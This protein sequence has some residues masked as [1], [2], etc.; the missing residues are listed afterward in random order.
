MDTN[1]EPYI[2]SSIF[3]L[4]ILA[5]IFL[6]AVCAAAEK[7]LMASNKVKSTAHE[8]FEL[9]GAIT[10]FGLSVYAVVL[11][12]LQNN[13]STFLEQSNIPANSFISVIL[14]LFLSTFLVL[15]FGEIYPKKWAAQNL[16]RAA[17]LTEKPVKW[18][19]IPLMPLLW[20]MSATGNL[21]LRITG[22]KIHLEDE[23]F[24]EE[25]VMSMLETGKET[26]ALKEEGKKMIDSIFAF[27]DKFAYEI[28]TPRTNVFAI[29][30][31]DP[32]EKYI[33]TLMELRYSRI[34]VFDEDSDNIIGIIH[35]KDYLIKARE[36]GFENVDLHDIL[37]KPFFVPDTK[38]IDTLFFELQKTRQH[39]AIL[40]DEYGG[41]SGI[42]TLEDIIEEVMGNIDDE[43]DE[44]EQKI[45]VVDEDTYR[46]DGTMYLDD[47]NEELQTDLESE[48]IETLGGLLIEIL[49]EIPADGNPGTVVHDGIYTFTIESVQDRRIGKVLV[50]IEKPMVEDEPSEEKKE[51]E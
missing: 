11:L 10:L 45:Q 36:A 23:E 46:I 34:P 13:L 29:N 44:E 50:H 20:F 49:G 21:L 22:Q 14:L 18:I 37:R 51:K 26:G 8:Q 48:N 28:M 41:F 40:I 31:N 5:L 15:V 27:D 4:I 42:V 9:R 32:T 43:Y 17:G 38:Y 12:W 7:S 6:T 39:I 19:I 25:E 47:I 1:P 30:I 3:I 24:S 2:S 33:D 16:D 35:I